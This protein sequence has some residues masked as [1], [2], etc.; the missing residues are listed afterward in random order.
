[1]CSGDQFL[2]GP[3]SPTTA[4]AGAI[5][6]LEVWPGPFGRAQRGNLVISEKNHRQWTSCLVYHPKVSM[7][8]KQPTH[9]IVKQYSFRAWDFANELWIQPPAYKIVPPCPDIPGPTSSHLPLRRLQSRRLKDFSSELAGTTVDQVSVEGMC[10]DVVTRM[11]RQDLFGPCYIRC[12][13]EVCQLHSCDTER[14]GSKALRKHL[15][16]FMDLEPLT[17]QQNV[18]TCPKVLKELFLGKKK[19][20]KGALAHPYAFLSFWGVSC[21]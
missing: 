4:L 17:N 10:C 8:L 5:V 6:P 3:P 14:I 18:S 15:W 21:D 2:R 13:D 9:D 12:S 20:G 1:M 19:L 16:V 11:L 7:R